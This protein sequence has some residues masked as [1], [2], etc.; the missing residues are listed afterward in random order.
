MAKGVADEGVHLFRSIGLDWFGISGLEILKDIHSVHGIDFMAWR[1]FMRA[2]IS[3]SKPLN[4]E[5]LDLISALGH[6]KGSFSHSYGLETNS[7][8]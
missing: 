8:S 3:I 6:R 2:S 4:S 5:H 1:R 7:R